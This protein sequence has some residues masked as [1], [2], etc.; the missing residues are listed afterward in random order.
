MTFFD[1]L[2]K[3][4]VAHDWLTGKLKTGAIDD[5]DMISDDL[6]PGAKLT[7]SARARVVTVL[8]PAIDQGT[9]D[10][11]PVFVAPVD[12]TITKVGFV[13]EDNITGA[14]NDYFTLGF[15]NKGDDGSGTDSIASKDYTSGNDV[16]AFD[17]EDLGTVSNADLSAG[18][19]VSF[20]KTET[21]NGMATPRLLAVIV[22]EV[23][24]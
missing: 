13:P 12:C 23:T 8:I 1:I 21:G 14:D 24:D 3:F 6:V 17:F 7:E 15:V 11:I 16:T 2:K 4:S 9:E 10:E 5:A 19:V 20:S 22:Y 18:D